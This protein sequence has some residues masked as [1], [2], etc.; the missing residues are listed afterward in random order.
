MN[1]LDGFSKNTHISNILKILPL[2]DE[3]FH[4]DGRRDMATFSVAFRNSGNALQNIVSISM[5]VNGNSVFY[6]APKHEDVW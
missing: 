2:T 5:E 4:T 1:F 3:L 6:K